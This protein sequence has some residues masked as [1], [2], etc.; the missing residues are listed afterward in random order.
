MHT[1]EVNH[2][3]SFET[4][5][6]IDAPVE[7]VWRA[8]ADIGDIYRWNPGVVKSHATTDKVTGIGAGRHCD[9]GGKNYL[10]EEVVEWENQKQLTM[11]IIGTNMPFKTADIRFVLRADNERSTVVS[12]SP[13]YTLKFGVLGKIMYILLVRL[14]DIKCMNNM[15]KG[16]K[17]F[18]ETGN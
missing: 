5:I 3:A 18:I 7:E 10:D 13:E 14:T 15:L 6:E 12:V 4:E 1:Q 17:T 11:R 2:M 9:L 16:L 8:L